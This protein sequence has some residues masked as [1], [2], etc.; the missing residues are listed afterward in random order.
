MTMPMTRF[1]VIN[2]IH[3][4]MSFMGQSMFGVP[5]M[6]VSFL[7]IKPLHLNMFL[8]FNDKFILRVSFNSYIDT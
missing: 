7:F 6:I 2:T 8:K 1:V 5:K 4:Y 3:D